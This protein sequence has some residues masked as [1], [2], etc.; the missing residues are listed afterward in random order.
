MNGAMS[1]D[2]AAR[3][4]LLARYL[5]DPAVEARVR[6]D[7]AGEARAAGVDE[8]YARW[9]AGLDERR[10]AAFRRSRVHKARRRSG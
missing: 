2:L 9:L 10:V 5:D 3:Q 8:G 6:A 7:P 4:R 1:G